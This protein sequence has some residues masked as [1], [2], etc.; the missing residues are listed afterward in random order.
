MFVFIEKWLSFLAN[1]LEETLTSLHSSLTIK[2]CSS[3]LFSI[4]FLILFEF[5][6]NFILSY[7]WRCL[8][9]QHKF[10]AKMGE[11]NLIS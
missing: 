3:F 9:M 7:L 2:G 4:L 10:S 8:R 11:G 6:L 5:Y 1:L